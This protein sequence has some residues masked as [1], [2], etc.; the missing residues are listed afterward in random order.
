[1]ELTIENIIKTLRI[2]VMYVVYNPIRV[3][4]V[5]LV[6]LFVYSMAIV[7]TLWS[8]C[9]GRIEGNPLL[10]YYSTLI[11]IGMYCFYLAI[12]HLISSREISQKMLFMIEII[13]LVTMISTYLGGISYSELKNIFFFLIEEIIIV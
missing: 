3:M 9:S 2:W 1:M 10:L 13:V 6:Y 8:L 11:L 5:C 12:N 4:K 7:L